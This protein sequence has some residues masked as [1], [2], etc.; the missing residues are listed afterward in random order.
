[1]KGCFLFFIIVF[2]LISGCSTSEKNIDTSDESVADTEGSDD[3]EITDEDSAPEGFL[4]GFDTEGKECFENVP[5]GRLILATIR[6]YNDSEAAWRVQIFVLKDDAT[7]IDTGKYF[8]TDSDLEGI[9]F[10]SNGR[11]AAISSWKTGFVTLFAL[12][13]STLCIAQKE[14]ELPNLK[15]VDQTKERVIFDQIVA[16]PADPYK[17]Y[18]VSGNVL[19]KGDYSNYNG[20]IY[21]MT[22]DKYGKAVISEDHP[23]MHVPSAFTILPGGKRALVLGGKEFITEEGSSIGT[24]GPDDLALLDLETDIPEVIQWFDVWGATGVNGSGPSLRS[25]G[26]ADNGFVMIANSS[27]YADDPGKI[28][29]FNYDGDKTISFLTD[30]TDAALDSPDYIAMNDEGSVA[31]V[32][33]SLFKG[34]TLGVTDSAISYVKKETHD[35]TQPMIKLSGEPFQNHVLINSFRSSSDESASITIAEITVDGLV[36]KSSAQIPLED[37][38]SLESLAV[39]K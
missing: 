24:A 39:Q 4:S 32:L 8:E 11:L 10:N 34:A 1:M 25:I 2:F 23:E 35:L 33:N 36:E 27:E 6:N 26:V 19:E 29:L 31:I 13:D 5:D 20:G 30:F 3:S 15:V 14:I 9:G 22:V 18:L 37:G 16:N 12:I 17:F 38:Y 7:V 28:K 21:S